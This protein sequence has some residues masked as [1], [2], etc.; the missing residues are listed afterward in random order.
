MENLR[1]K[2]V[3]NTIGR[4]KVQVKLPSKR[5]S[6]YYAENVF[7]DETMKKY[8]SEEAYI[9]IKDSINNKTKIDRNTADQVAAAMKSWAIEKG[10]K[11]YTHWFQPLTG[12]TAEKHDTFFVPTS[13]GKGMEMFTGNELVQQEPDAS[14][15]PNGGLRQTFEARGY[16][17][18]DPT[19]PAFIMEIGDGLTLC[20]PTIFISY[21]GES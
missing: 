15:F 19:S 2:G 5:I 8:I 11:S 18:W 10:V 16:T 17:A 9:S 12:G 6:E 1:R 21:T 14:S 7:T 4:E 20:I 3:D 13:T